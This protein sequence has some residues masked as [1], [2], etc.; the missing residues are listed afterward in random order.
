V[1]P[2]SFVLV[3]LWLDQASIIYT[4][5]G[6]GAISH[7]DHTFWGAFLLATIVSIFYWSRAWWLGAFIGGI[8][9]IALDMFV[10]ADMSPFEP[11]VQGNPFYL[12]LME[13]MSLVLLALCAWLIAQYVSGI[14][15]WARRT[16]AAV[17]EELRGRAS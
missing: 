13:P 7:A 16:L 2:V 14:L 15:G 9:H 17:R 6:Y 3:N 1:H 5:T 8:S 11:L 4:L 12:G 10:H